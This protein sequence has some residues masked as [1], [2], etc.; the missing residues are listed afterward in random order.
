[1]SLMLD[2]GIR[3]RELVDLSV[4]DIRWEDNTILVDGKGN[5][6]RLVPMQT[7]LKRQLR[8]YVAIRGTLPAESL[9]VNIDDQT[10]SKRRIQEFIALYGR[11]ANIQNVRCS[12]HTFRH[13]F[14]KMSVQNGADVFAL[15]KILGH[16]YTNRKACNDIKIVYY[17]SCVL[18]NVQRGLNHVYRDFCCSCAKREN[19]RSNRNLSKSFK[20]CRYS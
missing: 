7:T 6:E 16:T 3:A 14:A 18:I 8:K 9:F 15:Q 5:K 10:L 11:R 1:M 20:T 17:I 13:T 12:P 2:T 19:G 4:G